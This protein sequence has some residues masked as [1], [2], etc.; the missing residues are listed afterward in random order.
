M[1]F[2]DLPDYLEWANRRAAQMLQE[3]PSPE[4]VRIFAHLLAAEAIWAGRILGELSAFPQ[5]P[6]WNLAQC[7]NQIPTNAALYRDIIERFSETDVARYQNSKGEEFESLVSD[8]LRH[9]F[10]HGA[11]HRGQLSQEVKNGGGEIID[12]DYYIFIKRQ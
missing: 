2:T 7:V 9:V 6:D 3:T 12:T 11:Y 1:N 4:G 8:L 5:R 10:A